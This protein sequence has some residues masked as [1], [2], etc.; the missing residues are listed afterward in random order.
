MDLLFDLESVQVYACLDC[1]ADDGARLTDA[2]QSEQEDK[3]YSQ[4][5]QAGAFTA[6]IPS[7]PDDG[8]V[9][10][11]QIGLAHPFAQTRKDGAASVKLQ[12]LLASRRRLIEHIY[13]RFGRGNDGLVTLNNVLRADVFAVKSLVGVAVRF[14]ACAFQGHTGKQTLGT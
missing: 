1:N 8:T 3:G 11:R 14:H 9:A 12:A 7:R 5:S 6:S 2:Q 13:Q 4:I 10:S